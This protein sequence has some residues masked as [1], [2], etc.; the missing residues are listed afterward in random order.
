MGLGGVGKTRLMVEY[1]WRYQDQYV[2]VLMVNAESPVSLDRELA[3][4]AGVLHANLDP[5]LP[6]PDRLKATLDSAAPLPWL[7]AAGG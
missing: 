4:L 7:V 2:A 3:S 1:A 6:E 5:T